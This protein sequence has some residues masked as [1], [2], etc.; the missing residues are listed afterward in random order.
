MIRSPRRSILVI[1][2]LILLPVSPAWAHRGHGSLSVV[3]VDAVTG[4]VTVSHRLEAHDT[5]PALAL[6]ALQRRVDRTVFDAV[7]LDAV[8]E[9]IELAQFRGGR[10]FGG[11]GAHSFSEQA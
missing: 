4:K 9:L 7:D 8:L 6:V 5:E 3:E 2:A 10:G 1:A 11:D